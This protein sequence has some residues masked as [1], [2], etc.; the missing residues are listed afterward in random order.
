M[1]QSKHYQDH[2]HR[3]RLL[4]PEWPLEA[5][6]YSRSVTQFDQLDFPLGLATSPRR[7]FLHDYG[8]NEYWPGSANSAM[9]GDNKWPKN[10]E[11]RTFLAN[12][13]RSETHAH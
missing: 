2:E 11:V 7:T 6:L 10:D 1:K 9:L 8:S 13:E 5:I 3:V 12:N 4:Y